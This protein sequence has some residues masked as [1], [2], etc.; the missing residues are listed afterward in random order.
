MAV[1]TG[2]KSSLNFEKLA[3]SFNDSK[4]ADSPLLLHHRIL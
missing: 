3:E 1:N 2:D 4:L